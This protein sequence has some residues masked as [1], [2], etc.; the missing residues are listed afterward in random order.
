MPGN[1]EFQIL[2]S[3]LFSRPFFTRWQVVIQLNSKFKIRNSKLH[4]LLCYHIAM[5]SHRLIFGPIMIGI[6]LL[7]FFLDSKLDQVDITGTILQDLFQG[8]TY[9][10]AGLLLLGAFFVL[11]ILGAGELCRIFAAKGIVASRSIVTLA[12][13]TGC[14]MMFAIPQAANAQMTMGVFSTL[15]ALLFM[16]SLVKH[17]WITHKTEGAI[18]AAAVTMF[19][20]I[21][22]GLL[23]GFLVA[24]RRWYSPW[25]VA[26]VLL[27][28]KSCDIGA[29][30]SGRAF[31]KHKL[32]PWLSPGKTWEGLFGGV[33]FSGLVA[34]L[35]AYL[36]NHFEVAGIYK[37]IDGLRTFMPNDFHLPRTFVAGLLMGAVGQFGDLTASLFKRDAGIKDSGNTIPGFG[38][39]LDV[40]DSPVIVAPLAYW[41][42]W[43][44]TGL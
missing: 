16:L 42:L 24:I 36:S 5:L 10:P 8:R 2:N 44:G 18:A 15:I 31:G 35:L 38:G 34:L 4:S 23:P 43:F 39:V 1:F 41:L 28:V 3:E 17:S 22:M 11:I 27:I 9:L 25:V 20:L 32:I 26:A 37:T 33:L 6:L 14:L 19:A 30:F 40:V 29:Y 7:T 21:Y 13:I 12:G